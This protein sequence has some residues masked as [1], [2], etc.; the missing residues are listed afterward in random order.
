MSGWCGWQ[1]W[2]NRHARRASGNK[3]Q[4]AKQHTRIRAAARICCQTVCAASKFNHQASQRRP[5]AAPTCQAV[6]Q[7]RLHR[8]AS[9]CG[10]RPE[11][12]AHIARLPAQ[13]CNTQRCVWMSAGARRQPW[14]AF[15]P[16]KA[17]VGSRLTRHSDV[18]GGGA[19]QAQREQLVTQP[20][21]R[22][23]SGVAV[24]RQGLQA[25]RGRDR[26]MCQRR[27][28]AGFGRPDRS[29]ALRSPPPFLFPPGRPGRGRRHCRPAPAAGPGPLGA[30]FRASVNPVKTMQAM[31]MSASGMAA[32]RGDGAARRCAPAPG[33]GG[34]LE[35]PCSSLTSQWFT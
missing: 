6:G 14:A 31:L 34:E 1:A 27:G 13:A 7:Q 33:A 10:L 25:G 17:A 26:S 2:P 19:L 9:G 16:G 4:L 20:R 22:V 23:V 29:I 30:P 11:R 5:C 12:G 8:R 35:W 3:L 18:G 28:A 24:G 15:V 21:G 32:L